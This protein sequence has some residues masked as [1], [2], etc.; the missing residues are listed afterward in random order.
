MNV[1]WKMFAATV[2][3]LFIQFGLPFLLYD[4]T[5]YT[6]ESD[7]ANIYTACKLIKL[8][9][10]EKVCQGEVCDKSGKNWKA[11]C[12]HPDPWTYQCWKKYTTWAYMDFNNITHS[13]NEEYDEYLSMPKWT[14]NG[15]YPCHY[16]PDNPENMSLGGPKDKTWG[17]GT[18]MLIAFGINMFCIIPCCIGLILCS[19]NKPK[20]TQLMAIVVAPMSDVQLGQKVDITNA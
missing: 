18:Y 16:P 14:I 11:R 17:P 20:K 7:D 5:G 4:A 2:F 12:Q 8:R 10:E 19:E 3:M 6:F 1:V 13:K 9:E 15:S